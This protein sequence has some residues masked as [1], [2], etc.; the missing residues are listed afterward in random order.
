M[1]LYVGEDIVNRYAQWYVT[2]SICSTLCEMLRALALG[3]A[4]LLALSDLIKVRHRFLRFLL[5]SLVIF[6]PGVTALLLNAPFAFENR[7]WVVAFGLFLLI[8]RLG[9]SLIGALLRRLSRRHPLPWCAGTCL[10]L[11]V[12][13]ILIL[14]GAGLASHATRMLST[15]QSLFYL[16]LA[17]QPFLAPY[18]VFFWFVLLALRSP[19]YRQRFTD[20][21]VAGPS[22]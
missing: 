18:F 12:V 4:F 1:T 21:L 9:L 14:V 13:S 6:L 3:L 22:S 7:V 5:T 17:P 10:F 16:A 19:F 20:S 2:P 8:F 11:G 15:R